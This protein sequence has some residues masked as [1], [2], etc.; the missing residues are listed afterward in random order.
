MK[1]FPHSPTKAKS[2]ER[3]GSDLDADLH[4]DMLGPSC[5][6][7]MENT[8]LGAYYKHSMFVEGDGALVV[9]VQA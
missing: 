1:G 3:S 8:G 9:E 7:G 4:I 2:L 5:H 6:R